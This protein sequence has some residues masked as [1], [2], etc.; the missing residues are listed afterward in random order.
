MYTQVKQVIF[1]MEEVVTSMLSNMQD[2]LTLFN[3]KSAGDLLQI[4]HMI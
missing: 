1:D 3:L 2:H 4:K